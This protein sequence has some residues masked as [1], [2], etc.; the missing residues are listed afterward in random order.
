MSV[1]IVSLYPQSAAAR[2]QWILA[3][4]PPRHELDPHRPYAF[5]VEQ[6]RSASGE[7]VPVATI[8]LTNRECPWRCVMCDLWRNTLTESVAIGEIPE[9]IDYALSQ[10]PHARHIKLYNSGSFFDVQAI[11]TEDYA[12]IAKKLAQF[13]RV[14]VESHPALIGERVL[15]FRDLVSGKLEVA[16]GLETANPQVL[17]RL[18]KRITLDLFAKAAERLRAE[19]IDLRVFVL[20]QP[21]FLPGVEALYWA[22][23]SVDFAF[24]CGATVVTLIPTRSGNGAMEQL[25]L[26]GQFAPPDLRTLEMALEYGIELRRGRVFAD[27]WDIQ[28]VAVCAECR[29]RRVLRLEAMNLSQSVIPRVLCE[30]C[31]DER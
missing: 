20:V 28:Q 24:D 17:E 21:P 23:R 27:L 30:R 1:E 29:S 18:N 31:G 5:V 9:Q 8:F 4:R 26:A 3:H 12:D 19:Q 15:R 2:D 22:S 16:I 14:I 7:I 25:Q 10:L 11:P 13:E 6:E